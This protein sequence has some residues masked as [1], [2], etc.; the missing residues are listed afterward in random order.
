MSVESK[1]DL[2]HC[3]SCRKLHIAMCYYPGSSTISCKCK[4]AKKKLL[5][6]IRNHVTTSFSLMGLLQKWD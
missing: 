2:K 6:D 4:E 1:S 5:L 3:G